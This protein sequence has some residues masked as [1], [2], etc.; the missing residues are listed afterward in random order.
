M[1]QEE[2][3]ESLLQPLHLICFLHEEPKAH[4]GGVIK[5]MTGDSVFFLSC[6]ASILWQDIEH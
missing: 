5:I 3:W 6:S 1:V 2:L 4:R